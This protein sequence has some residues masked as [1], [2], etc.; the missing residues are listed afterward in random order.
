[1]PLPQ[2]SQHNSNSI[3]SPA[4]P[5][6]STHTQKPIVALRG[7]RNGYLMIAPS[8][9]I[10]QYENLPEMPL[11]AAKAWATQLE[12]MGAPRAYWMILS[13]LTPHLHIH[14]F[15]R[16]PQD[17][18]QGISLFESRDTDPQPEWTRPMEE[19]L[20]AWAQEYEVEMLNA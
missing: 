15:P 4:N 17:T 16:W 20:Q 11:I 12:R 5:F 8:Q 13:E 18:L 7:K 3:Q 6:L 14:I 1:M 19:A 2:S 9:E 10:V